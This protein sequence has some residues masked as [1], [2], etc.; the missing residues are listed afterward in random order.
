MSEIVKKAKRRLSNFDFSGE[1]AAIALVAK[2]QGGAA[3]GYQTLVMKSTKDITTKDIEKATMVKVTMPFDDFLEKFFHVYSDDAEMLTAILGFTDEEDDKPDTMDMSW[4]EYKAYCE[5]E[6]QDFINSVEIMKSVKDGKATVDSLSA[7]KYLKVLTAQKYFETYL[8]K[9]KNPVKQK[10]TSL[11][12]EEDLSLQVD[13]EKATNDLKAQI[14]EITKAKEASDTALAAALVDVKKA[15]DQVAELLKEKQTNIEKARMDTLSK[16][17]PQDQVTD[18][19][20]SLNSLDDNSF[21]VVVK[22]LELNR[23]LEDESFKEKGVSGEDGS[24]AIDPVAKIIKAK[25][26]TK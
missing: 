22:S 25:Y 13:I 1:G 5:Q 16:L 15:K 9:A 12:Q 19:F 2:E 26:Q 7:D 21:A 14:V 20:K 4:E 10:E 24:N 3:N 11:E 18:L 17:V 6:K 23:D 8:E